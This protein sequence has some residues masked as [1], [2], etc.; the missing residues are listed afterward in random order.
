MDIVNEC[1]LFGIPELSIHA[2]Y[3]EQRIFDEYINVILA[4]W[5]YNL[6]P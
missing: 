3:V 1:F 5:D 4:H 6:F 2:Q